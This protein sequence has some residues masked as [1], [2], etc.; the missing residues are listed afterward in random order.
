MRSIRGLFGWLVI[1]TLLHILEQFLFGVD[2]LYDPKRLLAGYYRW[3]RD[4]ELGTAT[5]IGATVALVQLLIYAV[6]VRGKPRLFAVGFFA[7][8]ALTEGHHL[9]KAINK[10]SYVPGA[11]TAVLYVAIG[12]FLLRA[13]FREFRKYAWA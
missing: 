7:V 6:L 8:Y 13:L 4:P 11:A 5:L 9:V 10:A 2:E 1:V 3:F 12:F